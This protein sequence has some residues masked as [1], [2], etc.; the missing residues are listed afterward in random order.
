MDSPLIAARVLRIAD[1]LPAAWEAAKAAGAEADN[2][3]WS[4]F[5]IWG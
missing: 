1:D 3:Y 2:L 4:E 5:E